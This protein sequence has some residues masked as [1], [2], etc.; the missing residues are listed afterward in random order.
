MDGALAGGGL[1]AALALR[2]RDVGGRAIAHQLL[3]YP[4][5]DD[6]FETPLARAGDDPPVWNRAGSEASWAAIQ[7]DLEAPPGDLA[8]ARAE[9]L[10]GLPPAIIE[11]GT[12]DILFDEAL[13]YASR[14]RAAGVP[15]DLATDAGASTTATCSCPP[16]RPRSAGCPTG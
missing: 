15:V 12:A 1:A 13:E 2:A 3:I 14:L 5:F 8:P 6:R 11:V 10:A 16:P 4:M 9:T 7:G